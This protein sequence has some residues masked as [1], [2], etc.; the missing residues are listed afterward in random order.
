MRSWISQRTIQLALS[1]LFAA[2]ALPRA[3]T[4]E[5][6][7]QLLVISRPAGATVSVGDKERGKS[8]LTLAGLKVGKADVKV[9]L[10]G[11]YVWTKRVRLRPGGNIVEAKLEKRKARPAVSPPAHKGGDEAAPAGVP[12]A[13][14]PSDEMPA[15]EATVG[16]PGASER[17]YYDEK[18]EEATR[19]LKEDPGN[20]YEHYLDRAYGY[21]KKGRYAEALKDESKAI[22]SDPQNPRAYSAR[23]TTWWDMGEFEEAIADMT[24][25]IEL[26]G[27][28]WY[29][30][31]FRRGL[32]CYDKGDF[33]A[34]IRNFNAA[35]ILA[36]T[37]AASYKSRGLCYQRKGDRGRALAD[38]N[39]AVEV[40]PD[41][42]GAHKHR[43]ELRAEMGR[44][45]LALD[46]HN[47]FFA[48]PCCKGCQHGPR[49]RFYLYYVG[50]P[51]A[52]AADFRAWTRAAPDNPSAG[53]WLYVALHAGG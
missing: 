39:K 29:H 11:Y 14:A 15:D 23:A 32:M 43:A 38:F 33:D 28:R 42:H 47:A 22:E 48:D 10:E 2:L 36:G 13:E 21:R 46:D 30:D 5:G 53:L 51:V 41:E 37:C 27:G 24:K 4:A 40:E 50:D 31:Y 18:I 20:A 19:G 35:I 17:D 34:A 25:V 6:R 1:V 45:D 26:K 9:V 3:A 52:A 44:L 16:E 12:D 49:G 7:C 8:P